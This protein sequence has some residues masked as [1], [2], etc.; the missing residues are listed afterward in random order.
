[1]PNQD[2]QTKEYIHHRNRQQWNK[3]VVIVRA[4]LSLKAFKK[5]GQVDKLKHLEWP[6]GTHSDS[7]LIP[8]N[9][10]SASSHVVTKR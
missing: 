1:M 4:L 9:V 7:L 2:F 5:C 6:K 3:K 10:Q 8:R